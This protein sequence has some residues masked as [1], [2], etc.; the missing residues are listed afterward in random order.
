MSGAAPPLG[1]R[2]QNGAQR[3]AE[4][5]KKSVRA[6]KL[7][8]GGSAKRRTA[9][10]HRADSGRLAANSMPAGQAC[11]KEWQA[12]RALR[13]DCRIASASAGPNAPDR[14]SPIQK[15]A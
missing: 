4:H 2:A 6:E 5:L 11:R 1:H 8:A 3:D 10:C 15:T 7:A 12:R 14:S 13:R 9:V